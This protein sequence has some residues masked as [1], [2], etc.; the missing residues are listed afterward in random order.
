MQLYKNTF[1]RKQSSETDIF[2]KTII[3]NRY[4][5][6]PVIRD[7]ILCVHNKCELVNLDLM[8]RRHFYW[9]TCHS[10]TSKLLCSCITTE[11]YDRCTA[12]LVASVFDVERTFFCCKNTYDT[13]GFCSN[14]V[15]GLRNVYSKKLKTLSL[16]VKFDMYIALLS[17]QLTYYEQNM[18][19]FKCVPCFNRSK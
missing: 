9:V 11:I 3:W 1:S 18:H 19:C 13:C 16:S 14:I 17:E 8:D 6:L 12:N 5:S 7:W 4:T 10:V 2:E 15:R